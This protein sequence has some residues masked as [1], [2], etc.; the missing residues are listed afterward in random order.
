MWWRGTGEVSESYAHIVVHGS[1][2]SDGDAYAED[3]MRESQGIDVAV[4]KEE[5][6]A[7]ESPDQ[8]DRCKDRVGQV[9]EREEECGYGCGEWSGGQQAQES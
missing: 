9:R 7:G 1:G 6:A 3:G 4:A 5:Q 8:G 2:N